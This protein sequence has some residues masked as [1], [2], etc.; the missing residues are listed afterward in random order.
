M[1]GL[2]SHDFKIYSL[3]LVM[4]FSVAIIL[5]AVSAP[6]R[7]P[8][9][10]D[11]TGYIQ[12][13]DN[14][15]AGKGIV[16]TAPLTETETDLTPSNVFPPGYSILIATGTTF[17]ISAADSAVWT[18]RASWALLP[19]A[20]FFS[21]APLV[22]RATA[23]WCSI[24]VL[25]SPGVYQ[26]GYAALSDVPFLL[27]TVLTFG[28]LFRGLAGTSA[29]NYLILS[30][31]L[32]GLGYATRNVGIATFT[33]VI[34]AFLIATTARIFPLH[35]AVAKLAIWSVSTLV[36]LV[37]LFWRNAVVFGTIHPYQDVPSGKGLVESSRMFLEGVFLDMTGLPLIANHLAWDFTLL[38]LTGTPFAVLLII[39]MRQEFVKRSSSERVA[40][41][42]MITYIFT[43]SLVAILAQ[44]LMSVDNDVEGNL[45]YAIQY[46]WDFLALAA[47]GFSGLR[48]SIWMSIVL[49]AVL[50][51]LVAGRAF[52]IQ[53]DL[54]RETQ[55]SLSFRNHKSFVEAAQKLHDKSWIT[56]NQIKY[57]LSQDTELRRAI[58]QLPENAF[59]T[60]NFGPFLQHVARPRIIRD[61]TMDNQWVRQL[62]QIGLKVS[63]NRPLY[64]IV[65]PN[66]SMLKSDL[67]TTWQQMVIKKTASNFHAIYR[68]ENFII[69]RYGATPTDQD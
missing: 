58:D 28:S 63:P 51:I 47:I 66:N 38:L 24:L 34:G 32:A 31:I 10:N 12:E 67:A 1:R 16:R 50:A 57:K 4:G 29:R 33:A 49:A 52:Y 40:I 39:G 6:L 56:T 30:G 54:A 43:G 9:L 68:A 2:G 61:M 35:K 14:L 44:V 60:S 41:L 42:A 53:Q 37:P 8:F 65:F 23:V 7:Y 59:I 48:K 17:G 11:S 3:L 15:L 21:L 45:R 62:D 22:G 5:T 18:T 20:L 55:I 25:L 26:H 64:C 69:L 36:V 46:T 19:A 13:A 27:L